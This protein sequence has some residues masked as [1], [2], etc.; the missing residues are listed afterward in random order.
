MVA[1]ETLVAGSRT[2]GSCSLYVPYCRRSQRKIA[3]G[4]SYH[5]HPHVPISSHEL[6]YGGLS[7]SLAWGWIHRRYL[8]TA[9]YD[10][11]TRARCWSEESFKMPR[12]L[13]AIL[14]NPI[15]GLLSFSLTKL[16]PKRNR[17][18]RSTKWSSRVVGG[19][20]R[21]TMSFSRDGAGFQ[22]AFL[23][24][25]S[26][27]T[28]CVLVI[29]EQLGELVEHLSLRQSASFFHLSLHCPSKTAIMNT[30]S[31][32]AKALQTEHIQVGAEVRNA[33]YIAAIPAVLLFMFKAGSLILALTEYWDFCEYRLSRCWNGYW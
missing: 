2:S 33:F 16:E 23:S 22:R 8:V 20:Q 4:F 17:R 24:L 12:R 10:R 32:V 1:T 15:I 11:A 31:Y 18:L 3:L 30:T 25:W 19:L 28:D 26:A 21:Y 13:L 14:I 29:T 7:I 9:N 5:A 27:S 6:I